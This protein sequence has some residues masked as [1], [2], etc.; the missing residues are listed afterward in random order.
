M[1]VCVCTVGVCVWV[2]CLSRCLCSGFSLL[3]VLVCRCLCL[4][5]VSVFWCFV[6]VGVLS[7]L[8]LVL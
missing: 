3:A 6:C 1:G 2:L 4:S 7:V 5:W 8:C